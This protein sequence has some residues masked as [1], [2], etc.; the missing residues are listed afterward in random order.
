MIRVEV[1]GKADC[2]LC[3]EVK[4]VLRRIQQEIPFDL[5]DVDVG[6]APELWEIYRERV[7]L[8]FVNGRLAFKYRVDEAAARR[9]L[10]L[11]ARGVNLRR[12]L[13]DSVVRFLRS[14]AWR[15]RL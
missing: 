4:A 10:A 5:H 14:G 7:P 13:H 3:D 6:A 2:A 8:V 11:E 9:R 12:R 1:Y 15:S